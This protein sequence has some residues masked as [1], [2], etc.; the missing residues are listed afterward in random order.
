MASRLHGGFKIWHTV[1]HA[2]TPSGSCCAL[3]FLD[4]YLE[5]IVNITYCINLFYLFSLS[6]I[7]IAQTNSKNGPGE[8]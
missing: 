2:K 4:M 6:S 8:A 3:Y 1:A 7:F 5:I